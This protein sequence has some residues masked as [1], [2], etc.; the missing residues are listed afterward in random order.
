MK[1]T[2]NGMF[3]RSKKSEVCDQMSIPKE[4]ELEVRPG[5]MLVQKRTSDLNQN[6][7]PF[8]IKIKVKHASTYHEVR[9]SPHAS[10][11]KNANFSFFMLIF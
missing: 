4:A 9:I 8:S 7:V 11:G 10:F 3:S 1:S 2:I 5:G 6:S